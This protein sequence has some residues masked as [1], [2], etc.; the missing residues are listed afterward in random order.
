MIL[1]ALQGYAERK[2]LLLCDVV[3]AAR[4]LHA[5]GAKQERAK[6]QAACRQVRTHHRTF[7][8]CA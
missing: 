6:L 3:K 8:A 1:A 2:V 7:P 4:E 5:A